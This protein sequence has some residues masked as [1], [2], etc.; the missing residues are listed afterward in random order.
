MKDSRKTGSMGSG[1][2]HGKMLI[3]I[4]VEMGKLDQNGSKRDQ[5]IPIP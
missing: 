3:K 4:Q 1:K 5:L 2:G